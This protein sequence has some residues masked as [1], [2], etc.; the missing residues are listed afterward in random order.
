MT[1]TLKSTFKLTLMPNDLP[2]GDSESKTELWGG[3]RWECDI[4]VTVVCAE[5]P[6]GS[7]T[8]WR[9]VCNKEMM[10]IQSLIFPPLRGTIT[11]KK[12]YL[13]FSFFDQSWIWKSS[14]ANVPFFSKRPKWKWMKR[15]DRILTLE[16]VWPQTKVSP[17]EDTCSPVHFWLAENLISRQCQQAVLTLKHYQVSRSANSIVEEGFDILR[18]NRIIWRLPVCN[19]RGIHM[20]LGRNWLP[21][22]NYPSYQT[23]NIISSRIFFESEKNGSLYPIWSKRDSRA[24]TLS[25][26]TK[27]SVDI[28]KRC[29]TSLCTKRARRCH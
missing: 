10:L 2:W 4:S 5:W 15:S 25:G 29:R 3:W 6:G 28:K 26:S 24:Q 23:K 13:Y 27:K 19:L 18:R 16:S 20:H 21:N 14:R 7:A 17:Q 11:T 22:R 8:P 9:A 1:T 12:L